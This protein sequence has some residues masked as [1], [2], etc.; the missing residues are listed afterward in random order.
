MV[1][2]GERAQASFVLGSNH[3]ELGGVLKPYS[4]IADSKWLQDTDRLAR[5]I[6]ACC[7]GQADQEVPSCNLL[8]RTRGGTRYPHTRSAADHW[9]VARVLVLADDQGV[10][11]PYPVVSVYSLGGELTSANRRSDH[12]YRQRERLAHAA[13]MWATFRQHGE[14]LLGVGQE[15]L[16]WREGK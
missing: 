3:L 6:E 10:L 16:V 15:G 9:R 5:F 1:D 2:A 14:S 8:L 4:N 11:L 7:L 13:R 12:W